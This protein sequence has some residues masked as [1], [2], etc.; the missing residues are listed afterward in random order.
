MTAACGLLPTPRWC[1]RP[2]QAQRALV[3]PSIR[4]RHRERIPR[5]D[6]RPSSIDCAKEIVRLADGHTASSDGLG[7][8]PN[9]VALVR[10]RLQ[11][12]ELVM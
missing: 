6:A 2:G 8:A 10:L 12:C 11:A 1:G 5:A 3:Q 7:H 9:P 4:Y